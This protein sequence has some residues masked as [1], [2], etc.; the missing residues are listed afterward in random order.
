[1]FFWRYLPPTKLNTA[2]TKLTVD[3]SNG[4]L[5]YIHPMNKAVV[6]KTSATKNNMNNRLTIIIFE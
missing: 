1:M 5:Q 2:I 6:P 3:N 4:I